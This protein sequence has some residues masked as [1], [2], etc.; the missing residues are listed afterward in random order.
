MRPDEG[1]TLQDAKPSDARPKR[2]AQR[3]PGA[4]KRAKKRARA[5]LE[6]GAPADARPKRKAQRRPARKRVAVPPSPP[7]ATPPDPDARLAFFDQA[8]RETPYLG[9]TT[10]EGGFVVATSDSLGR[11]LFAKRGRPEFKVLRQAVTAVHA[12][13]GEESIRGRTFVDIGANIGTSTVSAL[14]SHRF[15]WGVACE[16]EDEN[17]RLLRANVALN[18]LESHVRTLRVAVSNRAGRLNLVVNEG[19]SGMYWIA[20]DREKIRAAERTRAKIAAGDPA[21]EPPEMS[22]EEVEVVTLDQLVDDGVI[23]ADRVGMLWVDVEGHEGHVLAGS[24]TL[25][26]RGVPLVL[27]FDRPALDERGEKGRVQEVAEQCYTHFVDVRRPDPDPS[28]PRFH[29]YSVGELS[30]YAERLLGPSTPGHHTDL[31]L[32]RLDAEQAKVGAKLPELM[33]QHTNAGSD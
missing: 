28:K 15:A 7:A 16:P 29:L 26:E 33:R 31:L 14:V 11:G 3:P 13:I 30:E 12:V 25:T 23:D 24:G 18:G 19:S 8:G 6:A 4:K 1:A 22:V 17:Y 32:V 5:A 2:K 20:V 9:V 21:A 27:E 10:E